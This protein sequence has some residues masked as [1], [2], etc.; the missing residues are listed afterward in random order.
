MSDPATSPA[1]QV[2]EPD[3]DR[4]ASV[5]WRFEDAWQLN[6]GPAI[7]DFLT[8]AGDPLYDRL[9]VELI[10]IDQESR[11]SRSDR[12]PIEVYLQEWPELAE[13]REWIVELLQAE[14][15]TRATIEALPTQEELQS[16]F[17][18]CCDQIDL[19]A[20]GA[21]ALRERRG[22]PGRDGVLQ[23][24]ETPPAGVASTF[25]AQAAHAALRPGQTFGRYAIRGLLGHGG[26]G[27]VYRAHDSQLD[28][29]VALKIP[30]LD[31]MQDDGVM[32]RLVHEGRLAASI[33][34]AHVCAVYDAGEADGT[35]Y[36]ALRLVHGR[37]LL[38]W[39]RE[40]DLDCREAAEIVR[41]VATA[42][43]RVHDAGIVH[44]DVKTS[45]IM[46]DQA[47]E[48]LL[49]DF[50]LALSQSQPGVTS[51]PAADRP[52]ALRRLHS[53]DAPADGRCQAGASL[54][55][56]ARAGPEAGGDLPESHCGRSRTTLSFGRRTGRRFA[57]LSPGACRVA[58]RIVAAVAT[59]A[60]CG[61]A[62]LAA[63][64]GPGPDAR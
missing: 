3:E 30:R 31:L 23:E 28:R 20:V 58:A 55:D 35:P 14:C 52:P 59:A 33:A 40:R 26:M 42:L 38:A 64:R 57:T 50:G 21:L 11:W 34:H 44:R 27:T 12:R 54:P 63:G 5:L 41:K 19:A 6:T 51:V 16:R 24:G 1:A 53:A 10:K 46:I 18:Q 60:G 2:T 32:E 15:L 62:D 25:P 48:P 13:R 9:L 47:G 7:R 36:V 43:Q 4:L 29:E 49:M 8:D 39:S 61:G 45:N 22:C 17:R 37:S 56:P